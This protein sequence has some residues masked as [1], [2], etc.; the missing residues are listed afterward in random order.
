MA[1]E[2]KV[3]K[4]WMGRVAAAE[5]EQKEWAE[6][7]DVERCRDYW[8]GNQL[9]DPLD[10]SGERKAQI[11]RILPTVRAKIPSLYFY[12]PFARVTAS[13]A[14]NDTPGETVDDKA[15]LLQD[16]ANSLIR[17]PKCGLKEQTLLCLKEAQWAFGCVEVGYSAEFTDNPAMRDAAPPLKETERTEGVEKGQQ[18]VKEEWFYV[19]RI[20][21]RQVLVSCPESCVVAENDWIGYWEYQKL[22]DVKRAPAYKNTK[23]LKSAG[24]DGDDDDRDSESDDVK[25]FKIWDQRTKMRYVF[26]EGHKQIL[27]K[28]S[29][30][31]LPLF[32]LRFE[33]EPDRFRP[34]PPIHGWLGRQDQYNT[35][36]EA[37]RMDLKTRVRR[38]TVD[39]NGLDPEEMHKFENNEPN[40]WIKRLNNSGPDVISPIQQP[41][42]SGEIVQ[43][44]SVA[45]QE[46][47]EVSGVG[48]EARQQASSGT[49]TQAAIMNQRQNIQDS[50]D[51]TQV[52]NWLGEIIRE[53]VLLAIDKMTLE[54]WIL[55]N[56]DP[57]SP[58]FMQDAQAIMQ[59]HQQITQQN[60]QDANDE[61]RWDVS[62]D[63]ESLSP[64]SEQEKQ[65][66]WMQAL[67]LISNPAV[68]PLLALSEQLLKRTLDL[69]GIRSAKDQ[70]AIGDALAQKAQMEMQMAQQQAGGPPGVSP[71]PGAPGP[72][73]P[74]Q[75]VPQVPQMIP[76][77]PEGAM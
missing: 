63:V 48:A 4:T 13:P 19:K 54:R 28:K 49:A 70:A 51:R 2:E 25:L 53:L 7:Y 65:A 42:M 27:L 18:I 62:V 3:V 74:G 47:D 66:Q 6:H 59:Q 64:V 23:D 56:S 67:N 43:M 1:D 40:V 22:E 31:R 60:L 55:I 33:V 50:F 30:Q 58:A 21:A 44:M 16:T 20:P 39:A 34:I 17:D 71:M 10:Q 37:Y 76:G 57:D 45:K 73:G 11:N 72:S 46:F 8:S 24:R 15:Q 36:A 61:L 69:N 35:A 32:F 29:F 38:F 52:A 41:S 75:A 68:A 26:A 9:D 5:K 12:N 77:P 14:K